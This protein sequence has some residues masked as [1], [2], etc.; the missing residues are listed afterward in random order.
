MKKSPRTSVFWKA[1]CVLLAIALVM[2]GLRGPVER[3]IEKEVP[4]EKVVE[5]V[6][7]K[8][9]TVEKEPDPVLG[10]SPDLNLAETSK[11]F[12]FSSRL[13]IENG[14]LASIE[15]KDG[16]AYRSQHILSVRVPRAAATMDELEKAT[17]RLGKLI[18]GLNP[19]V[20]TAV[21]S[22]FYEG[23]YRNK[24][25]RLRRN[26]AELGDLMTAHNFF[27]CQTML[28]LTAENGRKVFLLQGDMDV[29]SDGSDGDRLPTMPDEVVN[30]AYYQ[31]TTSYGWR[32]R[33]ST[34]NPMIEG[35]ERRVEAARE[36]LRDP[37]VGAERKRWV[38]GRINDLLLP[39][40]EEMKHRSFL[41]AEYDPF[42]VIP[43]NIILDRSDDWGPKVGD[44]AVVVHEGILYPAIVGDAGPSFKVGEASLRMARQINPKA[45]PYWRPVSDLTVTYLCF[46]G[47][48]ED[49]HRPPDYEFWRARCQSLLNE[50]GGLGEGVELFQWESTL[51]ELA[52]PDEDG[53]DGDDEDDEDEDTEDSQ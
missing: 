17:P 37:A 3:T 12:T 15:R 29:V 53:D 41:V 43:I 50:I 21:V 10:I 5:R 47:S 32:K 16:S 11:G 8:V 45:G 26:A 1:L 25:D 19:L 39:G 31:P 49:P 52:E 13:E 14:T 20:K 36:E 22:N 6:V 33:G 35:Y 42:V 38:R 18:P 51:P 9:V 46:P 34:P 24:T 23:M 28:N 30:S 48:G 2:L 27:D 7:E 40:I 4:V 44:Y